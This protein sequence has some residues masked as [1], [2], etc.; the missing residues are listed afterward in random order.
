MKF[1]NSIILYFSIVS[2]AFG[3]V[4]PN[5]QQGKT[6]FNSTQILN[7]YSSLSATNAER[8]VHQFKAIQTDVTGLPTR[9]TFTAETSVENQDQISVLSSQLAV[10]IGFTRESGVG[11]ELSDRQNDAH[12][13]IHLKYDQTYNGLPVFT[14]QYLVHIYS[15]NTIM[16][17]GKAELPQ[18]PI[19]PSIEETQAFEYAKEY[20]KGSIEVQNQQ[21]IQNSNFTLKSAELGYW[22]GTGSNNWNLIYKLKIIED[23]VFPWI[24]YVDAE[25]GQVLKGIKNYCGFCSGPH[26]HKNAADVENSLVKS[27]CYKNETILLSGETTIAKDLQDIDRTI[28]VWREGMD[29]YLIDASKPMFDMSKFDLNK[30]VGAIWTQDAQNSNNN[31]TAVQIS[32]ST[33]SFPKEGVSAHYIAGLVYDYFL[34]TH[35]RNSI[36]GKGGTIKSLINFDNNYEGAFWAENTIHYGSGNIGNGYK[37]FAGSLDVGAHEITHGVID[38]TSGLE[39]V[40]ESGAINESF[41]D[42]FGVMMD[43]DDWGLGEEVI[44]QGHPDFPTGLQRNMANPQQGLTNMHWLWQPDH[45]KN[46][47]FGPADAGGVH[48]NSGIPNFAFYKF[49]QNLIGK[50]GSEEAAKQIAEKVY[51]HA[52]VFYVT[53]Q[54][55][56]KELRAAIEQSCIDLYPLDNE[57]KEQASKAF[58]A[59]GIG[60]SP[61]PGG[62]VFDFKDDLLKPNQGTEYVLCSKFNFNKSRNEG[63]YCSKTSSVN[64]EKISNLDLLSRPSVLDDGSVM[65][66]VATD[67]KVYKLTYNPTTK[68]WDQSTILDKPNYRN[69][70]V[71]KDGRFLALLEKQVQNNNTIIIMDLITGNEKKFTISNP[72]FDVT[73]KSSR[74]A[75]ISTME[76]DHS[77][78]YLMYDCYNEHTF[79]N[80]SYKYNQWDIGFLRFWDINQDKFA[81]GAIEKLFR[82]PLANP[83]ARRIYHFKNPSFSKNSPTVIAM[84]FYISD[85]TK[86]TVPLENAVVGCNVEKGELQYIQQNA[87]G[88]GF[89]NY[90]VLDDRVSFDDGFT[91]SPVKPGKSSVVGVDQTKMKSSGNPT[92]LVQSYRWGSF[93]AQGLRNESNSLPTA[94]DDQFDVLEDNELLAFAYINDHLSLDIPNVFRLI[95]VNGGAQNGKVSM[96]DNGKF[97]YK[98]NPNFNGTDVFQYELCDKDMDCTTAKINIVVKSVDDLPTVAND[99]YVIDED[100]PFSDNVSVNDSPSGDGGNFWMLVGQN[101][102]AMHGTVTMNNQGAFTYTAMPDYYGN[103]EFSYTLCDLDMDCVTARVSI[104]IHSGN[105]VPIA[106]DDNFSLDEDI[107][108]VGNVSLNDTLSGDGSNEFKLIGPNGGAQNADV[109]MTT[110]GA[111]IYKPHT[112]YNGTDDFT[113]EICDVNQDCSRATVSLFIRPVNDFP[114]AINDEFITLEDVELNESVANNDTPSGDIVDVWKLIGVNGGAQ[115]GTVVFNP[116]GSFRYI[117]FLDYFGLDQF[118][119][120]LCDGNQDCDTATVSIRVRPFNDSPQAIDDQFTILK[121]EV[122]MGT[123]EPN[124]SR[125]G[126]GFNF[127]RLSGLN[128]GAQNGKVI[129]NSDG[130][131]KYT[132]DLDFVGED[133]FVYKLCDNFCDCS[134][135]TVR[136]NVIASSAKPIA[137]DDQF[138]LDEDSEIAGNL[139]AN[140]SMSADGNNQIKLKGPNGG[141]QYGRI[142]SNSSGF[143]Y[144][145]P[146]ANYFGPDQ[147]TYILCDRNN[148]CSEAVAHLTINSVNDLPF[149]EDDAFTFNEDE[150]LA[151][152]VNLNDNPSGDGGNQWKLLGLNGGALR[153][154]VSM[155]ENGQIHYIP[156]PDFNGKDMI[157]YTLC[158][159]NNDCATA[160]VYLTIEAVNDVPSSSDDFESLKQSQLLYGDVS[161]NDITSGDEGNEWSLDGEQGGALHGTVLFNKDGSYTYSAE[162]DYHGKD[163]FS[164]KLCDAD[165][166]CSRSR[167][168]L[169]IEQVVAVDHVDSDY[170]LLVKPNPFHNQ[171]E[172]EFEGPKGRYILNV[173]NPL[174]MKLTEEMN[175][176]NSDRFGIILDTKQFNPGIYILELKGERIT[177]LKKLIR[178]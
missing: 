23:G 29:V 118:Q 33:N 154:S 136:I 140:D 112:N 31:Q 19:S 104:R 76:F 63:L 26:E 66:F 24:I 134:M 109:S 59:V 3:Q 65:Y 22:S 115:G 61:E 9:F 121:N 158:D 122:L 85:Y 129:M 1:F 84:D 105:D 167:V 57:I 130:T 147:F 2:F 163:V 6:T 48:L 81:D 145:K 107:S 166:D 77:G 132:P 90:S 45:V 83:G 157:L 113:Y 82:S 35:N 156:E 152:S 69:V 67:N 120:E 100:K 98:P 30:P 17:H 16:A 101:G 117:P 164:Y 32:S 18:G 43:R 150:T 161:A 55:N 173:Y 94:V 172:I 155:N 127:W 7:G 146:E 106:L 153:G 162:P 171:A 36:D 95:G 143:F 20:L 123:V 34:N 58:E 80:G 10:L 14:G 159:V 175:I 151:V 78:R 74:V 8:L 97:V 21:K 50:A 27:E 15:D 124:D 177:V 103:D 148:D 42:I 75:E 138:E 86:P 149:T 52:M 73:V 174:G 11:F 96:E 168:Y 62:G 44:V 5:P 71:A 169:N 37:N 144:Y 102:G 139:L 119:Y 46:Q 92:V 93:F 88:F 170:S 116:D 49:V 68:V 70:A 165:G 131:F 125:S 28:N 128:G 135:A 142:L 141:A 12:N 160:S 87:K 64:L 25:Q 114:V 108:F 126:D 60:T 13:N 133:Q 176:Q 91:S 111:F 79:I 178:D 40:G 89:P 137:F 99:E 56:F 4:V 39:Y 41:A 53:R 47:Y 38:A 110:D 72:V 51:Y 54:A